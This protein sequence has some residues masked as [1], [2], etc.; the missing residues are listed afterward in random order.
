MCA[1][2]HIVGLGLMLLGGLLSCAYPTLASL[3]VLAVGTGLALV[4]HTPGVHGPEVR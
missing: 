2:L 3:V 4:T 1:I